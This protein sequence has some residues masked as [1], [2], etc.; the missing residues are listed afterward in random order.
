MF[1]LAPLLGLVSSLLGLLWLCGGPVAA[2]QQA[3]TATI[4]YEGVARPAFCDRESFVFVSTVQGPLLWPHTIDPT[5]SNPL[6]LV[7]IRRRF[8]SEQREEVRVPGLNPD[9][10]SD[11]ELYCHQRI[12][13]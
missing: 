1:L 3:G 4:L 13:I 10:S 2:Q 12:A 7:L 5:R 9:S 11:L 6:D 8:G